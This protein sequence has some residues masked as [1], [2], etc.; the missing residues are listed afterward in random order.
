MGQAQFQ[1]LWN[2]QSLAHLANGVLN[3]PQPQVHR[4]GI[5]DSANEL[6]GETTNLILSL[7]LRPQET[8]AEQILNSREHP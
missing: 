3:E 6:D 1:P 5:D 4:S 2:V 8:W 7:G